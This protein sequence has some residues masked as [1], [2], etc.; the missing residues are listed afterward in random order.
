MPRRGPNKPA[1][2][3]MGRSSYI[4]DTYDMRALDDTD[5]YLRFA[6]AGSANRL[7]VG[8][9]L[10]YTLPIDAGNVGLDKQCPTAIIKQHGMPGKPRADCPGFHA[11]WA[12][13]GRFLGLLKPTFRILRDDALRP[14]WAKLEPSVTLRVAM[15]PPRLPRL[16]PLRSPHLVS[17]VGSLCLRTRLQALRSGG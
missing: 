1:L 7:G 6:Y 15:F 4:H 17:C 14:E 3:R 13:M 16:R 9:H 8:D 12:G 10:L 5:A 2:E 11:D